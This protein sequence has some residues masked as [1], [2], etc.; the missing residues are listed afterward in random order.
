[1]KFLNYGTVRDWAQIVGDSVRSTEGVT[2]Q[3]RLSLRACGESLREATEA[4]VKAVRVRMRIVGTYA[5]PSLWIRYATGRRVFEQLPVFRDGAQTLTKMALQFL[6][7]ERTWHSN[8]TGAAEAGEAAFWDR[9]DEALAQAS[10]WER[11]LP[12]PPNGTTFRLTSEGMR[13]PIYKEPA[14]GQATPL[15]LVGGVLSEAEALPHEGQDKAVAP[16]ASMTAATAKASKAPQ[17]TLGVEPLL[18]FPRIKMEKACEAEVELWRWSSVVAKDPRLAQGRSPLF[19]II[20]GEAWT[21]AEVVERGE[22]A[23]ESP[24]GKFASRRLLRGGQP[25]EVVIEFHKEAV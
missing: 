9:L 25:D 10:L 2:Q 5:A 11:D 20:G 24:E 14:T 3:A 23:L 21:L 16:K 6:K 19:R 8:K 1:M 18:A 22:V 17:A 7:V 12:T 15:W 4:P 13:P